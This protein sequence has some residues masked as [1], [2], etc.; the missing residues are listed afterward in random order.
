M[1]DFTLLIPFLMPDMRLSSWRKEMKGLHWQSH[2]ATRSMYTR[3]PQDAH[4]QKWF[5]WLFACVLDFQQEM[6]LEGLT[7]SVSLHPEQLCDLKGH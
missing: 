6:D 2:P 7:V 4:R 5:S 1:S 3:K